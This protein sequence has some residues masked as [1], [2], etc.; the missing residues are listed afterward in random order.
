MFSLIPEGL[1]ALTGEQ[2]GPQKISLEK[3]GPAPLEFYAASVLF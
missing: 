3:Y 2:V 1:G